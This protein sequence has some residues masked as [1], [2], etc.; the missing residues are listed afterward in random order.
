MG[1]K[2]LAE[3]AIPKYFKNFRTLHTELGL[4]NNRKSP[5]YW[6]LANTLY[7]LKEFCRLHQKLIAS[8]SFTKA[9]NTMKMFAL[10][11][12]IRKHD[13][14]HELNKRYQLGLDL[15]NKKWTKAKIL[16]ELQE[17][18]AAGHIITRGNLKKMG[19]SKLLRA[20]SNLGKLTDFKKA[21]KIPVSKPRRWSDRLIVKELKLI[22]AEYGFFPTATFLK[23]LGRYD[24][25]SAIS[26]REGFSRFRVL[27]NE[28]SQN[29]IP[30]KDKHYLQSTYECIF[31]NILY[32]Y[33]IPHRVHV[34]ISKKHQY[35]C[36]FLIGK[37]YIEI[38]G[39]Y[40][41]NS[42]AYEIKMEKKKQLYERLNKKFVIIPGKLFTRRIEYI[43]KE[44]LG[45]I[46]KIDF[47]QAKTLAVHKDICIKPA[48]YWADFKNVKKELIPFIEKY[49]RMPTIKELYK[50]N[51]VGLA[52]AIYYYH[53]TTYEVAQRLRLKSRQ[54][55]REYYTEKKTID[56][57]KQLC[58]VHDKPLTK[59]ELYALN[60]RGLAHAIIKF[61]GFRVIRR[62]C[63]LQYPLRRV[64]PRERSH[65]E[66]IVEYGKVCKKYRR[67][68]KRCELIDYGFSRLAGALNRN[69]LT[70]EIARKKSGLSFSYPYPPRNGY[71][72]FEIVKAY[73]EQC[74]EYG[75]FLKRREAINVLPKQ[76]IGF[77]DRNIGYSKLRTL[78]KLKF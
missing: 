1:Y 22:I 71:T 3:S 60:L 57:Y 27:L 20:I 46:S 19:R 77:I 69:G 35:R 5:D 10:Q 61:K 53:G 43:E 9:I 44:V 49:G 73:K 68:L 76:M 40:R 52:K 16:Q 54:V 7:E 2:N 70:L 55:S 12:A 62:R 25:I 17:I 45:I 63:R 21:A 14:M 47:R 36:D 13:G 6:T 74:Q 8:T 30:A 4:P 58:I 26:N 56:D 75:Y 65:E 72:S 51:K 15:R 64:R 39:Y 18:H 41:T 33:N 48:T 66:I 37:T 34:K 59:K 78:T 29:L 31:D 23:V 42:N 32:K 11:N 67:F 38:A 50:N 28:P 24:L